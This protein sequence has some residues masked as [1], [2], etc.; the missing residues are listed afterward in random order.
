[1]KDTCKYIDAEGNCCHLGLK[2]RLRRHRP[3]VFRLESDEKLLQEA[4]KKNPQLPPYSYMIEYDKN[5]I[6]RLEQNTRSAYAVGEIDYG[7]ESAKCVFGTEV[8][9]CPK[10][11]F[12]LTKMI[13]AMVGIISGE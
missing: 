12:S 11:K 9:N 5:R 6:K 2:F 10:Y 8:R 13:G 1:M 4:R 7:G 3:E